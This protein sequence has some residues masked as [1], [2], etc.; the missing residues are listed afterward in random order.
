MSL[1][2]SHHLSSDL[3]HAVALL[4]ADVATAGFE[5][6][7]GQPLQ[8][9]NDFFEAYKASRIDQIACEGG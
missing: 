8:T 9:L 2:F 6:L 3:A 4:T 5:V 1:S 7:T